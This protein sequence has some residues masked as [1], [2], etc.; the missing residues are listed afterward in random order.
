MKKLKDIL[1]EADIFQNMPAT[2]DN[3]Q[4]KDIGRLEK[5]FSGMLEPII[6]KINTKEELQQAVEL[7]IKQVEANKPGLAKKAKILLRKT[8]MSL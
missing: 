1:N 2:D 5:K 4:S 3:E 8:I 7:M 6:R